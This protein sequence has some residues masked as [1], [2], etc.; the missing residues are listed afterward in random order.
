MYPTHVSNLRYAPFDYMKKK[1]CSP[2]YQNVYQ[3]KITCRL[4]LRI[5]ATVSSL[6]SYGPL[7]IY[8]Y[9]VYIT[10]KV[11]HR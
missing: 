5:V 1:S 3:V 8:A 6:R 4:Q 9:F 10:S 2:L 7:K 11:K